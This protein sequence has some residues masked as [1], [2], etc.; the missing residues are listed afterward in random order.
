MW[1][2]FPQCLIAPCERRFLESSVDALL[3]SRIRILPEMSPGDEGQAGMCQVARTAFY[4]ACASAHPT[5][6]GR[7]P[8]VTHVLPSGHARPLGSIAERVLRRKLEP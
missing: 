6:R 8:F 1:H 5:V 4:P 7:D 3:P 2:R